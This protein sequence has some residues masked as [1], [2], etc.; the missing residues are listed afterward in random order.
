MAELLVCL[1]SWPVPLHSLMLMSE[2]VNVKAAF[3]VFIPMKQG[4]KANT[5]THTHTHTPTMNKPTFDWKSVTAFRFIHT[6]EISLCCYN[7]N[8]WGQRASPA[9]TEKPGPCVAE[10]RAMCGF[11]WTLIFEHD[12]GDWGGFRRHMMQRWEILMGKKE[13]KERN[14]W[15]VLKH[16]DMVKM[17][18]YSFQVLVLYLT[19]S[20]LYRFILILYYFQYESI[21]LWVCSG[22]TPLH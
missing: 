17:L 6:S 16:P 20:M 22:F 7:L 12:S 21:I 19:F 9:D 4:P 18:K 14:T 3:H 11:T 1:T 2:D 8:N 13:W 10:R 5:H 15:E